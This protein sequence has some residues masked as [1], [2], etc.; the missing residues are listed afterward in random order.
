MDGH[1]VRWQDVKTATRESPVTLW[2]IGESLAGVP[3][4]KKVGEQEAVRIST[5]AML[6]KGTDTVVRPEDTEEHRG[7]VR[8]FEVRAEAQD[9][10]FMGE[11][12]RA[13]DELVERG[14]CLTSREMALLTPVGVTEVDACDPPTVSILVTG[15]EL[16]GAH[17]KNI[18]S[19]QIRDSN[20]VML[21][22]AVK[23][24]G[25]RTSPA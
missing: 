7:V 5:E 8:I 18:A 16:A 3:Y 14:A 1:A 12:F 10:R 15:T 21:Y 6:P 4:E 20:S 19:C 25:A 22:C 2:I 11:E 9:V 23:E 17:E 13:G 24:T